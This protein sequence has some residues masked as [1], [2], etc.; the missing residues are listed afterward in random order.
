MQNEVYLFSASRS[1]LSRQSRYPLETL[2]TEA[3]LEA[4]EK[5]IDVGRGLMRRK[6]ITLG[7]L[8]GLCRQAEVWKGI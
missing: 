1:K 7:R 5:S 2:K 4:T 6:S 8:T 3:T